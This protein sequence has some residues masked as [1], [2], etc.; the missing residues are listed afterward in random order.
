MTYDQLVAEWTK[1]L[2]KNG[3]V[4][5][6]NDA[7][8]YARQPTK[9]DV[10]SFLKTIGYSNSDITA[11]LPNRIASAHQSTRPQIE[12]GTEV[13]FPGVQNAKFRWL[14]QQWKLVNGAT[15]KSSK[16][17]NREVA[18]VLTQI[19]LGNTPNA[20]DIDVA[21]QKLSPITESN[22]DEQ[23]TEEQI[24][25]IFKTIL[26]HSPDMVSDT[27]DNSAPITDEQREAELTEIKRAIRDKFDTT[28]RKA[29]WRI[30]SNA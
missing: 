24:S 16:V 4:K 22:A 25:Q 13:D 18:T 23:Y 14:G 17:A 11:S 2:S 3:V 9:F 26:K 29:L 27:E 30:L 12:V 1:Y 28:Q 21:K 8:Y 10:I 6:S 15:G 5:Q 7:T 19:A 20:H